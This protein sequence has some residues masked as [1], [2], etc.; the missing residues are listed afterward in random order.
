MSNS[1]TISGGTA[2]LQFG[3]GSDTLTLLPGSRIIGAINLGGG[4]DTVNFR[5]GNQNLTFSTLAG[6]TVTSQR[7]VRRLGQ[8]CGDR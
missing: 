4:G 8:S 7:A 3:G 2:A 1:G 5:T 6:K